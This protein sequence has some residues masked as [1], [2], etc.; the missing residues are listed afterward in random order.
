MKHLSLVSAILLIILSTTAIASAYGHRPDMMGTTSTSSPRMFKAE[1]RENME[2]KRAEFKTRF[3]EFRKQKIASM[4]ESMKRRFAAAIE[5]MRGIADRIETRIDKIEEKNGG[6]LTE[7][8]RYLDEARSHLDDAEEALEDIS[9]T[10]DILST[11]DDAST[12]GARFGHLRTLL[13]GVKEH[14]QLA[15]ESLGKALRAAGWWHGK[16]TATTTSSQ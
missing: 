4:I 2:G 1:M 16:D 10:T 9:T 7:A 3:D 6:E 13:Q 12:T 8:S 11:G 15:R 5:R 14:L